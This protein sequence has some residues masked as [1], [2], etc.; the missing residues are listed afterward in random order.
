MQSYFCAYQFDGVDFRIRGLYSKE[1]DA[2]AH[3]AALRAESSRVAAVAQ[4]AHD[5]VIDTL[6]ADRLGML[7][8]AIYAAHPGTAPAGYEAPAALYGF[9][10]A[11]ASK[12]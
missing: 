10:V 9:P 8:H 6:V 1:E 4:Q 11:V 5:T 2:T 7:A 3:V 12:G